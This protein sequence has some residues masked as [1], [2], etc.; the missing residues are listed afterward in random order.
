[1]DLKQNS[2]S[3]FVK[4]SFEEWL[5][6]SGN[7]SY[8]D[9][10]KVLKASFC[11]KLTFKLNELNYNCTL[12]CIYNYFKQP[13][14]RKKTSSFWRGSFQCVNK[15]CNALFS[16]NIQ[17]ENQADNPTF[18]HI[19]CEKP[20]YINHDKEIKTQRCVGQERKLIGLELLAKG[21]SNKKTDNILFNFQQASCENR[22]QF[23]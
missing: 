22:K 7:V 11:N 14:S 10:R 17:N 12:K 5:E 20:D 19:T 21:V 23:Y 8:K 2:N 1:M 3:F 6:I 4:F 9:N 15:A 13:D 16:A 18:V